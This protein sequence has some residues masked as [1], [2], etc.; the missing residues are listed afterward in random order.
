[1]GR[2]RGANAKL[3]AVFESVYGTP[4]AASGN[5]F[6][7]PFVSSNIGPERAL[8][9]SDL[10][11]N[12]RESYDPTYDVVV[13]DGDVVVPVDVRYFGHWLKLLMGA[14][15]TTGA[16]P[17]SHS[18]ASGGASLPSMA[19]EVQNPDVPAYEMNYGLKAN[20]LRIQ[21]QRSGLL[22][23][24]LSLVGKGANAPAG[25]S[26]A[27]TLMAA[28]ALDR[29]AQATG[30]IKRN[31]VALASIV[32]ADI[33]FTNNLDKVETIQPD[34]EIE[35]ADAAIAM[36]SGSLVARFNSL[37]LAQD[38][39]SEAPV[40][41]SWKWTN[42][43]STLELVAPRVFL[44]KVKRPITGPGGVQATFNWQASGEGA[45][46]F[47]AELVNDKATY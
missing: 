30:Q 10:L 21:M 43:T 14:P 7:L 32:S 22:N 24:T 17:Y 37:Q 20:Q 44:P 29:F 35:D 27:G 36:A 46:C 4:P 23:A 38:A 1:M 6:G 5:Y 40:E 45:A 9:E 34:G 28:L 18:F 42:G 8:L 11:G 33:A 12:G 26:A 19:I 2:A 13:N 25:T 39:S 31:D 15:T 3:A 47:T 41:L 16:G